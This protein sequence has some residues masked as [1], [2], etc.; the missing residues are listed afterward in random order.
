MKSLAYVLIL[1]AL[2]VAPAN[3]ASIGAQTFPRPNLTDNYNS[4]ADYSVVETE[5]S[6]PGM[7]PDNPFYFLKRFSEDITLAF[8]PQA[9]KVRVR[10]SIAHTRLAE[11]KSLLEENKSKEAED[12]LDEYETDLEG[13]NETNITEDFLNRTDMILEMVR[14]KAS[15][16]TMGAI[17]F[18]INSSLQHMPRKRMM[19]PFNQGKNSFDEA[20]WN[21]SNWT[22]GM[23]RPPEDHGR[24]MHGILPE[25]SDH[26]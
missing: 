4:P 13:M 17:D 14:E 21:S 22:T 23:M 8:A 15:N 1:A 5:F 12:S 6:D 2:A 26:G 3:A 10:M 11:A 19:Q 24:G 16:D 7:L 25:F 9:D 20:G 18:A